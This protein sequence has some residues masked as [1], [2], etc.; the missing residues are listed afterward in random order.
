[1]RTRKRTV[2]VSMVCVAGRSR[3]RRPAWRGRNK[4]GRRTARRRPT[5]ARCWCG[6]AAATTATHPGSSTRT[7][8][9]PCPNETDVV[10]TPGRR[11]RSRGE[12]GQARHR[13]HRPDVHELRDA[14]RDGVRAQ[15]DA[16]QG[17]GAGIVDGEDVRRRDQER[18]THGGNGRAILPPMPWMDFATLPEADLKALYGVP[19]GD[20]VGAQP[21]ARAQGAEPVYAAITENFEKLK[22]AMQG[23][24]AAKP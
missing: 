14:V 2:T 12:T 9:C 3:S 17:D 4:A 23:A 7:W 10:R 15:P 18:Q 16:R 5:E 20:P 24:R 13:P 22:R 19:E 6:W 11:A 21:G 8:A 1:M